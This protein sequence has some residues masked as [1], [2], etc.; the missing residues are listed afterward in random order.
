[1]SLDVSPDG[2]TIVFDLLDEIYIMPATGGSARQLT[3]GVALNRQPRF[4]PDGQH[5][6][7]ISDRSGS[8]NV[9]VMDRSGQHAM[10][11]SHLH[12]YDADGAV[13]SPTWSPDGHSI[14]VAQ[15]VGATRP[16]RTG[17]S[18]PGSPASVWLLAQY[19][20]A[21]GRMRWISDTAY[22]HARSVLGPTFDVRRNELYAARDL[23]SDEDHP[24][25]W[26][27]VKVDLA[28]GACA[29]QS[30]AQRRGRGNARPLVSR[31]GRYLAYVSN[32][33]SHWGVRIRDLWSD[34]ERWLIQEQLDDPALGDAHD[35][36]PGYAFTP[37]SRSIIAGYGGK[38][39]RIDIAS[40]AV[41]LVPFVAHVERALG[42]IDVHQFA[43]PDTST[44][45]HNVMQPALS[46]DGNR[47]A[48]SALDRVWLMELPHDG[49]PAGRPIR[50]T[51]DSVGEFYPSWSPDGRW[52]VY[53]TWRDD[54]GGAI[55]RARV[56]TA[57]SASMPP[58]RISTDTAI[59]FNPIYSPT[60]DRIIAVHMSAASDRALTDPATFVP[61]RPIDPMLVWIPLRGGAPRTITSL[62]EVE[63]DYMRYP[64]RQ[65]Y[66][67]DD[68]DR[69]YIGLTSWRW[70]GTDQRHA[71]DLVGADGAIPQAFTVDGVLAPDRQRALVRRPFALYEVRNDTSGQSVF[72]ADDTI[73]LSSARFSRR[74]GTALAPWMSW[75]RDGKRAL[76]QEGSALLVGDR[77][78]SGWTLFS[79]VE[80]PLFVTP[81][82]PRG[83][84]VL[85]GAR[86]VTMHG[87]EVIPY[88]DIIVRDNRIAAVGAS[89]SV[90]IPVGA[91]ILDVRGTTILPGYIDIH[92][93]LGLPRGI[94]P[95]HS[96]RTLTELAY[97]VTTI[98]DPALPMDND[99]FTYGDRERAG[100]LL[101]PRLFTTGIPEYG[102][103]P[104]VRTLAAAYEFV[105]PYVD[106]FRSETFKIY[107]DRA[108]DRISR[109]LLAI[110]ARESGLNATVHTNGIENAIASIVDGTSGIEHAPD[111]K[112]YDDIATLVARSGTTQTE[113][114]TINPGA[115]I[116]IVRRY[117]RP[118]E[119]EKIRQFVP[120][121]ARAATC[122][123]C[124]GELIPDWGPTELQ[125]ILPIVSG[126]ARIVARGGRVAIGGHGAVPGLGT[127]WEMWL[128]ALG[129]MTAHDILLS[130]TI[131]GA[132]A[133]GHARDIGSLEPGKLADLQ[134]LDK[135]P[136][137]DIHNSTSIRFV[138]K[139][140]RLYEARDLTQ[141]WPARRALPSRDLWTDAQGR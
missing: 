118:V 94:H 136:L 139:N 121:S 127:H 112:I 89:G 65:L 124:S 73:D 97:G 72:A 25:D 78:A 102:T 63:A 82:M 90:P 20:V 125:S 133:I 40:G 77:A 99:A 98:R 135:N 13:V 132:S 62:T 17:V 46:P 9:W 49:R 141:V 96:W 129:G 101:G 5:I 130:A 55:W 45:V 11:L 117:G 35:F 74:W 29:P 113:T 54:A 2:R 120:P 119:H 42:P 34:H 75:S 44:R 116:Y 56:P 38:I 131:V 27:I 21:T 109:Q 60:G 41:A 51:A 107:Y 93:H 8:E 61:F 76:F 104:P 1:M 140:G 12:G 36:A 84:L 70:D 3:A 57:D 85:H 19:D 87:R 15:R 30:N 86:I 10:R 16:S 47:V 33:G 4:S 111:T 23:I 71:L 7:F 83:V 80:V 128:H 52:I 106:D 6:V 138:M 110:A 67:T 24:A 68:T 134:V 79:R 28:T 66:F 137:T 43:L 100:D 39:H 91:K 105:R 22:T 59:Y 14:V 18:S 81:D 103:D 108:T 31:D 58:Q 115:L 95:Q 88:G 114:Y 32:S 69:I 53:A 126:A 26:D 48:F 37:D 64:V 50:L 122:A 123:S 92:D